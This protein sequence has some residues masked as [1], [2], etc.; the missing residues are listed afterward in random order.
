[1]RKTNSKR[2]GRVEILDPAGML[3]LLR[4]EIKNAGSTGL[5]A[6]KVGL[7]PSTVHHVLASRR[8]PSHSLIKALG[9]KAPWLIGSRTTRHGGI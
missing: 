5:W 8:S 7:D 4:R 9:A 2:V 3:R 1:M 6:T